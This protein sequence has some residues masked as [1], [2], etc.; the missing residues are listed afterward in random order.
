MGKGDKKTT[1]G[2]RIAGSYGKTRPRKSVKPT[3]VAEKPVK[4]EKTEPKAK[5]AKKK[6][7]KA[8]ETAA[9]EKRKTTRKKKTEE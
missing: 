7:E 3:P 8:E 2:K 1:R 6:A 5:A 4:A 9:E